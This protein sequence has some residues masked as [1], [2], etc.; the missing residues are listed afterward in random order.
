MFAVVESIL[1][2]FTQQ[3]NPGVEFFIVEN[4]RFIA[5]GE[6]QCVP[7]SA[8]RMELSFRLESSRWA[9]ATM[10]DKFFLKKRLFFEGKEWS[11]RGEMLDLDFEIFIIL[12]PSYFRSEQIIQYRYNIIITYIPLCNTNLGNLNC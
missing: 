2:G 5:V 10:A 6:V 4:G 7:G 1:F 8:K 12:P 11:F 3:I 9:G